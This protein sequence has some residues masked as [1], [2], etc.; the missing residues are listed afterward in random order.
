MPS[1]VI[2]FQN[3]KPVFERECLYCNAN[4]TLSYERIRDDTEGNR[5]WRWI[6]R[7]MNT[8]Q[9][10]HNCIANPDKEALEQFKHKQPEEEEGQ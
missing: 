10:I 8:E 9:D 2:S 1:K 6:P 5:R 4:I 7:N 3:N